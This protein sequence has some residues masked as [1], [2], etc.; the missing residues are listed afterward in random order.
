MNQPRCVGGP[1][2]SA[3]KGRASS[4]GAAI[5]RGAQVWGWSRGRQRSASMMS[6]ATRGVWMGQV[7]FLDRT[8]GESRIVGFAAL[9][10]RG[11]DVTLWPE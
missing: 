5:Q 7:M 8:P 2:L 4:V 1:C 9:S 11:R 3:A 6:G 10:C